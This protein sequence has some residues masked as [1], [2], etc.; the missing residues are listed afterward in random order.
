MSVVI[1]A[2][3]EERNIRSGVLYTICD[4]LKGQNYTW[5]VLIADDGSTDNTVKLS[6]KFVQEH[7]NFRILR[8]PHRGKGGVV[9]AGMQAAKGEYVLFTDMDQATPLNQI[10]KFFPKFEDGYDVLIGSRSG[11][12]GA[13]IIRQIMSLG[14]V[15]LRT[16]VLRLPFKDTQCGFKAFTKKATKEIFGKLKKVFDQKNVI[17]TSLSAGFD[18]EMLYIARK[19]KFKVAEVAVDWHYRKGT[20]KNP[21]RESWVGFKGVIAV[22]IKSIL[23]KYGV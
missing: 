4:Y 10:E 20:A 17:G 19:M 9:I 7:A 14:F 2:Y 8:E 22:R 23:G 6:E 3:N 18:V 13:P 21:I 12:E 5:E 16:I 1:P 15:V 11:R